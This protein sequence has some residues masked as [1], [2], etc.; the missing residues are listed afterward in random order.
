MSNST[1]SPPP[2]RIP[3]ITENEWTDKVREFFA[4]VD[5]PGGR[6]KGSKLNIVKTIAHHPDMAI[7]YFN[8]G[9][10]VLNRSTLSPRQREMVTLRTAWLYDSEYEWLQHAAG[11]KRIGM[12]ADEIEAIKTGADAPSWPKEEQYLLRAVDQLRNTTTID[13][14]TWTGLSAFLDRRQLLD[15]LFIV[16]SYVMLAMALNA[17]RVQLDENDDAAPPGR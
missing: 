6:A 7:P 12:T 14:E 9:R 15:L 3:P 5:G 8:F 1:S 11:A 10:Y 17:L 2:A 13:D 4:L 16:G